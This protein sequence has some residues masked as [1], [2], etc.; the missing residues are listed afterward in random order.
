MEITKDDIDWKSLLIKR[1][2]NYELSELDVMVLF[3]SDALL[4]REPAT[5]ITCDV[6]SQ[7]MTAPKEDLDLSL[8][9]LLKKKDISVTTI[10]KDLSFTLEPFKEKL[11]QDYLHDLSILG[12]SD[13]KDA[14][15]TLYDELEK[16]GGG[17]LSSVERDI[18]TNWLKEGASEGMIKEACQK[19]LLRSGHIS[20]KTADKK[21]LEMERSS[22]QKE[23]GAS[24]VN[25]ET[26]RNE[27]LKDLF[28]NSDWTY[29]G[30][31]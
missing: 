16:I 17:T 30:D 10:G 18:V 4:K 26:R 3:V 21:V 20:F 1:Y 23:V 22:S 7:Y 15:T 25:E 14:S 27:K 12:Q 24:T 13:P 31:R 5:L 28:A 6:L 29:H 19:S 11:F 9:R 8:S 2:L